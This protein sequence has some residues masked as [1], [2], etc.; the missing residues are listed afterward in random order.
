MKYEPVTYKKYRFPKWAE[1]LGW[2]IAL[3]SI[4]AIPIYAIIFF[5]RQKGTLKEVRIFSVRLL[6]I[7]RFHFRLIYSDGMQLYDQHSTTMNKTNLCHMKKV[8]P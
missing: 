6:K 2:S 1:Y 7:V 8:L 3:S 5:A 4:V